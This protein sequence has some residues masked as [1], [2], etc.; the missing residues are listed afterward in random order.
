MLI[1]QKA[2]RYELLTE[3]QHQRWARVE[4]EPHV[5][6]L[7]LRFEQLPSLQCCFQLCVPDA[8]NDLCSKSRQVEIGLQ[9]CI[10]DA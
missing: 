3:M 4:L 2:R 1:P 5:L 8:L 9:R 10:L 6:P 7:A